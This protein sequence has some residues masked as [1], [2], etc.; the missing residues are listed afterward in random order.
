MAEQ[1]EVENFLK[2]HTDLQKEFSLLKLTKQWPGEIVF[3]QKELLYRNE[4]KR[5]VLPIYW[6][7]IAAAL[8]LILTGTFFMMS[9][10]RNNRTNTSGKKQAI[11]KVEN[12]KDHQ[13]P[14]AAE[15]LYSPVLKPGTDKIP[16]QAQKNQ[17]QIRETAK[18][19]SPGPRAAGSN[20]VKSSVPDSKQPPIADYAGQQVEDSPGDLAVLTPKSNT[21]IELQTSGTRNAVVPPG[22]SLSAIKTPALVVAASGNN[23]GSAMENEDLADIQTDNSIS[24]IAL[25]DRNK[26][27]TG[28]FK[29]LTQRTSANETADNTKK[30]RVSVFR[31]SY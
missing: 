9:I 29:K 4:E 11:V 16:A 20:S 3:D 17:T 10:L 8:V 1:A 21:G 28:F 25:N 2:E 18:H 7:R 24:V 14:V 15:K 31:F 27:I 26:G 19:D 12:K 22:Q 30:L 23:S 6:T 5:R 13:D